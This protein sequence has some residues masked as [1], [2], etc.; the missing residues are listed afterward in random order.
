MKS[1]AR[2]THV[3]GHCLLPGHHAST[4]WVAARGD[5]RPDD[6]DEAIAKLEITRLRDAPVELR[7]AIDRIVRKAIVRRS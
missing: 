5:T 2:H 4:C 6:I 7:R 1:R 3:C